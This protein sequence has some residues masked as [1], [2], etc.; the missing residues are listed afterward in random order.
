MS[1]VGGSTVFNASFPR[2]SADLDVYV[3]DAN[4]SEIADGDIAAL[5][6]NGFAVA[7]DTQ[8]Y[9]LLVEAK[10]SRKGQ[11]TLVEWSD[12]DRDR[13]FPVLEDP[14]F[15]WILDPV[16][17]AVQKLIA[18]ATR[19]AARD[20]VDILLLNLMFAP[21]AALAIAAPAK[22]SGASPTSILDRA[23]RNALGH[24][25]HFSTLVLDPRMPFDIGQVKVVL[26][27]A[28]EQAIEEITRSCDQ[29]EVGFVY[30]LPG[31]TSVQMPKNDRLSVLERRGISERGL[32]PI[33]D[34]NG[35]SRQD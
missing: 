11:S 18:A 19:R 4:L 5:R 17:L 26:A 9:G 22:L 14:V 2:R 10:V 7:V 16:D 33:V 3:E 1:F 24:R 32:V 27:D 34:R 20:V 21:L 23:L 30:C 15:G 6:S 29:A 13:F 8:F 35:Q 31:T 28:V 25:H 12:A